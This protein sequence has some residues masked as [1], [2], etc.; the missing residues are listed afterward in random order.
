MTRT[1]RICALSTAG[2]LTLGLP[3]AATAQQTGPEVDFYGHINLGIINVDNGA[4]SDTALTDNDNSN[5]RI[6]LIYKQ[7][8]GNGG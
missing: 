4:G 6:G 7:G 2:L 3:L 5:S 1:P 8:T